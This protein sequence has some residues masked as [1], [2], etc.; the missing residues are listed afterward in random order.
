MG[1]HIITTLC[2]V[3]LL[4]FVL[5][6]TLLRD[7]MMDSSALWQEHIQ[8]ES[9]AAQLFFRFIGSSSLVVTG[10]VQVLVYYG[11][12]PALGLTFILLTSVGVSLPNLLKLIYSNSRPYWAYDEVAALSCGKG[13]GNPSGHALFTGVVWL[14]VCV[15]LIKAKK[16]NSAGLPIMW[17][18]LIGL[19]RV[20]LGVHYYSQVLLGW[21]YAIAVVG[22][23]WEALR[24]QDVPEKP[25]T[26]YHHSG[27]W[28]ALSTAFLLLSL[29]LY[30]FRAPEWDPTWTVRIVSKCGFSYSAEQAAAGVFLETALIA[31]YPGALLGAYI[32]R[33]TRPKLD[34]YLL[35]RRMQIYLGLCSLVPVW[36][37]GMTSNRYRS[38]PVQ[39]VPQ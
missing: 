6:E 12:S 22:W 24:L 8:G 33:K 30:L 27:L 14:G 11:Y 37:Q 3:Q 17:L 36:L 35:P 5:I 21:S 23:C 39:A 7:G 25:L 31:F 2:T 29:L 4:V 34:V 13:W 19:D 10:L 18:L 28:H 15:L 16:L 32:L 20:Y 1:R 9:Q 26:Y 38:L